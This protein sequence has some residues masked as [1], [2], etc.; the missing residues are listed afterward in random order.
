MRPDNLRWGGRMHCTVVTDRHATFARLVLVVPLVLLA[1]GTGRAQAYPAYAVE[2]ALGTGPSAQDSAAGCATLS[3]WEDDASGDWNVVACD[4]WLAQTVV[5]APSGNQRHPDTRDSLVVY[6]DDRNGTWDIYAYGPIPWS[7]PVA[8]T[9][10]ATGP[11]DQLD[12]AVDGNFVVYEDT[13]HGNFDIAVCDLRTGTT[14]FLTTNAAAQVDPAIDGTTVV[15]ADHRNGNWDIYAYNLTR[16]T[17]KRLTTN[18]AAQTAPQIGQHKVVYQDHRS[19]NWDI[20]QYDLKTNKERRLTSSVS[21]QTAPSIDPEPVMGRNGTIVYA[22]DRNDGGDIYLR[23]GNTGIVKPVCTAAGAQTGPVICRE[24]VVWNDERDALPDVY[25]AYLHFP[26]LSA[27]AVNPAPA[28]NTVGVITGQLNDTNAGVG[29]QTIRVAGHGTVRTVSV[30]AAPGSTRGTYEIQVGR[31][32]R[33]VTLRVWYAG[34]ADHLPAAANVDSLPTARGTVVIKPKA[35]L[36][37]PGFT[38]IHM[39]WPSNGMLPPVKFAVSG[40]LLPHHKSGT[41]AVTLVVQRQPLFGEW[42]VY[43]TF[44]VAVSNGLGGSIYRMTLTP[45]GGGGF[46]NWRAYAVHADADHTRTQSAPSRTVSAVP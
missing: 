17:L 9:P 41:R 4:E 45:P 36:T 6:E 7:V 18:K 34:D 38:K 43:R 2:R 1:V 28:F 29:G 12:P 15:F 32:Q 16:K 24:G 11:G 26:E 30:S 13:S 23:D 37:R 44:K 21:D 27:I 10:V 14:R 8:E 3:A 33:K 31:L 39:P 25:S 19:G 20:Y 46:V 22:D 42:S 5:P 35:K 40:L